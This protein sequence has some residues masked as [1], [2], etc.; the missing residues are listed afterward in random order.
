MDPVWFYLRAYLGE[1]VPRLQS[2]ILNILYGGDFKAGQSRGLNDS[3]S[4]QCNHVFSYV[5]LIVDVSKLEEQRQQRMKILCLFMLCEIEIH[6]S[7]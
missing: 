5:A 7:S 4:R 2:H 6:Y 3:I 1:K